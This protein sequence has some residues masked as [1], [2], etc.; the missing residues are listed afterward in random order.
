M[1]YSDQI[2]STFVD[3]TGTNDLLS[4]PAIDFR[5]NDSLCRLTVHWRRSSAKLCQRK[6]IH[7]TQRTVGCKRSPC[8]TVPGISGHQIEVKQQVANG[9]YGLRGQAVSLVA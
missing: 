3:D 4:I 5:S 7:D 1:T 6:P 9:R 2:E 8:R